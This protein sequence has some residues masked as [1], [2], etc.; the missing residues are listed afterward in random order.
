MADELPGY[1]QPRLSGEAIADYRRLLADKK[2]EVE[3]P[4]QYAMLKTT[5]DRA[6]SE[7]GQ[8]LAPPPDGRSP[9]QI[10]HDRSFGVEVIGERPQLPDNLTGVIMRDVAAEVP[11]PAVVTRH[12]DRVGLE[13]AKAI[14]QAQAVLLQTGSTVKA[15]SLSAHALNQLIIYGE[16][17]RRYRATRP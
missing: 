14:E 15:E 10:A 6:I 11:D 1:I 5:F 7:T 8:P 4:E 17:L 12:L 16:H 3:H 2:M 13:Y 9:A